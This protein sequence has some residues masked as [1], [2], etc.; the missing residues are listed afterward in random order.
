[1]ASVLFSVQYQVEENLLK[2]LLVR[3]KEMRHLSLLSNL[4]LHCLRIWP[5]LKHLFKMLQKRIQL[6]FR[7]IHLQVCLRVLHHTKIHKIIHN[8]L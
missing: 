7:E 4:K 2:T 3:N 8:V 1:M 6:K 5:V